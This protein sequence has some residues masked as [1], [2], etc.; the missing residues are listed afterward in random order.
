MDAANEYGQIVRNVWT[1]LPTAFVIPAPNGPLHWAKGYDDGGDL[2]CMV[3][4]PGVTADLFANGADTL[5]KPAAAEL[6]ALEPAPEPAKPARPAKPTE[7]VAASAELLNALATAIATRSK[8]KLKRF[9]IE[10]ERDFG[11][12]VLGIRL[13]DG[14]P[15]A[16]KKHKSVGV[17]SGHFGAWSPG[18]PTAEITDEGTFKR[19]E[20]TA[21]VI[22]T[23]DGDGVFPTLLGL[24]A[25]GKPA[26]LLVGDG[27]IAD[28]FG[29]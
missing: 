16:W 13:G 23:A 24:D 27:L 9:T 25:N 2:V 15:V 26:C 12:S 14:A 20:L 21:H 28:V 8:K 17:D 1:V 19:G 22:H 10:W 18:F 3:F 7:P 6:H 4:G 11:E 5:T 29:D